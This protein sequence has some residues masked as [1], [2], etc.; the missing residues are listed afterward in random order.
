MNYHKFKARSP[1]G[2]PYR[3]Q[4]CEALNSPNKFEQ[5]IIHIANGLDQYA[6]QHKARYESPIGDDSVLGEYFKQ[7]AEGL[8]GLLNGECGRLDCGSMDVAIR[9][10][11]SEN[12]VEL[13]S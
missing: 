6:E 3:Y 8:L 11:A 12:N 4:H 2:S 13:D 9:E 5:P 7:I 10:I 1:L